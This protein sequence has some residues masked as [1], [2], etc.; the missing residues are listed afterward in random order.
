MNRHFHSWAVDRRGIA[1]VEFAIIAPVL[2]MLLGGVTDFGLVVAGKSQLANGLAQGAQYALLQGPGVT[3][4]TVKTVV[5]N[6]STR[7]GL[8]ATVTATVT[9]P[10]CYCS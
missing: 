9:G 8:T 4:A 7:S 2:L 5:Q 10:A 3:A 1:A 6:G